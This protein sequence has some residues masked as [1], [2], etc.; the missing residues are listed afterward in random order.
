MREPEDLRKEDLERVEKYL[1][2]KMH[3]VERAPFKFWHLLGFLMG[4]IILFGLLAMYV[5]I[6]TG[7][8]NTGRWF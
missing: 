5:A 2:S 3:Q 6:E 4:T 7:V 8:W 1:N